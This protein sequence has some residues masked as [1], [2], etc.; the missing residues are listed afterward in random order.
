MAD[1][2]I[3]TETHGGAVHLILNR[4]SKANALTQQMWDSIPELVA[5]AES[6]PG[7][8]VLVLRSAS[9]SVFSAGA[10]VGEYRENAGSTDWGMAN[11]T[12]VTAATTAI[13]ECSL[14]TIARISGPCAGGAVGLVSACD[15]RLCAD[16]ALFAV[17]PTKLG[18]VYP[19]ADTARLVDLIGTSATKRL[20]LTAARMDARWALRVGLIDES[21]HPEDLDAAIDQLVAQ[22]CGGA[23]VSVRSMKRTI[24]LANAGVRKETDETRELLLA[25]LNHPD[26]ME[27]TAA[28]LERRAPRFLE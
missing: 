14:A 15:F 25:A 5:Y 16:N 9:D 4:T 17:P 26:H 28:F 1:D 24:A 6:L 3:L 21:V 13:A 12:R 20:L 18:L 2:E 22:I 19:Q 11:H 8:R 10:D 27:G 7:A 23:P